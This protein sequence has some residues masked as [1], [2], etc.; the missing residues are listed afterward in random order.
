M[1]A[2]PIVL[3]CASVNRS[4]F[5]RALTTMMTVGTLSACTHTLPLAPAAISNF[6]AEPR[7]SRIT[8]GGLPSSF[9]AVAVDTVAIAPSFKCPRPPA[10]PVSVAQVVMHR[11]GAPF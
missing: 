8:A 6:K 2:E 4:L 5:V 11:K 1:T 10:L 3:T 9:L 7:A